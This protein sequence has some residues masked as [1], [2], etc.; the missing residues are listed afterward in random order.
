MSKKLN[1]CLH[2]GGQRSTLEKIQR[3]PTPPP[4]ATWHPIPH[5]LVIDRV[6]DAVLDANMEIAQQVHAL[7]GKDGERYFGLM[8]IAGA[9]A[10][11]D[12][13]M[14][15]GLRNSHDKRFPAGIAVGS[16]VFVCD[17]LA[18]TGE[19]TF[20]RKHTRHIIRDLPGVVTRAVGRVA[21]VR[22]LQDA[23]YAAYKRAE[24]TDTQA[25]DIMIRS[26]DAR[27]VSP[28]KLGKVLAE[29][30]SPRHPEFASDGKTAWRLY[31]AFT[32]TLKEY[33]VFAVPTLTQKL[34]GVMDLS[35]GFASGQAS[36]A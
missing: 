8:E 13:R 18:F 15:L 19:V 16:G 36:A 6:T 4:T 22:G 23:R 5:A 32:E 20:G 33:S 17:N 9:G 30:R 26:L 2:A 11:N 28:S 34:N 29:W 14:V 24:I 7:S 25:H 1:L 31:N 3:V 27:V 35:V 21:E 12:Y 10:S